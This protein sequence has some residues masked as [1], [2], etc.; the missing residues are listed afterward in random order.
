MTSTVI[1]SG[2]VA[3]SIK[4]IILPDPKFVSVKSAEVRQRLLEFL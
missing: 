1:G 2:S 3:F 4:L